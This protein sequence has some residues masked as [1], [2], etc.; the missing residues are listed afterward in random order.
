MGA[1]LAQVVDDYDQNSIAAV[2]S[3]SNGGTSDGD[4]IT[5]LI[6][7][8]DLTADW[9]KRHLYLPAMLNP[10][11]PSLPATVSNTATVSTQ[12]PMAQLPVAPASRCR[13]RNSHPRA[14]ARHQQN[15]VDIDGGQVERGDTPRYTITTNTGA[16]MR[17][18]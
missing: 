6:G 18:A 7:H 8:I 2:S 17:P 15:V 3:I 11:F 14:S 12:D 4:K 13:A 10:S 1:S 9:P 16:G 5:W